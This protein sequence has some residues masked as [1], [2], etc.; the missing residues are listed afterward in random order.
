MGGLSSFTKTI[1]GKELSFTSAFETTGQPQTFT[2]L[3]DGTYRLYEAYVPAGYIS[4]FRYIQ[5]TIENHV[6]KGVE[7][8]SGDSSAS[9]TAAT[10][11]SLALLSIEN[12][13]GEPLPNTGGPGTTPVYLFGIL[14]VGLAG[15]I[16]VAQYRKQRRDGSR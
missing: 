6:M 4:T 8:D 2:G 12:K 14:L 11:N 9:F 7:S 16:L 5:F 15:A 10:G 3:P 13:P 1:D